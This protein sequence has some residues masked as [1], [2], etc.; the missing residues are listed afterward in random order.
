MGAVAEVVS[1]GPEVMD[2]FPVS[3]HGQDPRT[4]LTGTWRIERDARTGRCRVEWA[5]GN[6]ASDEAW[7]RARKVTTLLSDDAVRSLVGRV[8]GR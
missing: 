1:R 6:I 3:L 4:G 2:R 8:T 7:R 5:F